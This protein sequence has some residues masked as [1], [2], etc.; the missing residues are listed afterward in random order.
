MKEEEEEEQLS[1]R[2]GG[3]AIVV[4]DGAPHQKV[5]VARAQEHPRST[6]QVFHEPTYNHNFCNKDVIESSEVIG[7]RWAG[8][9]SIPLQTL[10]N[11]LHQIEDSITSLQ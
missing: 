11:E 4:T 6:P 9:I 2:V 10:N 8:K 7:W 5:D 3:D 1:F